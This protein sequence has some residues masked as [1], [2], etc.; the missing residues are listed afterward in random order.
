VRFVWLII[1]GIV[2]MFLIP[3]FMDIW[4]AITPTFIGTITNP[5]ALLFYTIWPYAAI[6]VIVV[7]A[8]LIVARR[9]NE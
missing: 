5:F 4:N 9:R 3:L 2:A 6:L 1:G 8:F 7:A